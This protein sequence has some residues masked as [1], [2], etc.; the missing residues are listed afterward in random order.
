MFGC[1]KS[2]TPATNRVETPN[3]PTTNP[4]PPDSE[5][6]F[7]LDHNDP[8]KF[9][10]R[11][12]IEVDSIEKISLFR[13]AIGHDYSDDFESCRSMKHYFMPYAGDWFKI[14]I[15]S[16]VKGTVI[17]KFD[18]WAGSQI[19][20]QSD[21]YPAFTFRLFHVHLNNDIQEGT[22]LH[23]GQHIGT[24]ISSQTMSDIAVAVR[25]PVDGPNDVEEGLR[26][27]SIFAVM[28][29][30]LFNTFSAA[31]RDQFI[32]SADTRDNDAIGC[33]GETFESGGTIDNWK[34]LN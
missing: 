13:S 22:K 9:V 8:P 21:E 4:H 24:H 16:P 30:S 12:Y 3:D 29:D 34:I 17:R 1:S 5:Y 28:S 26:L 14:K 25:T 19:H 23:A 32:I 10:I 6:T 18:E 33:D 20:I 31:S 15:F 7:D 11:N 2:D 27:I